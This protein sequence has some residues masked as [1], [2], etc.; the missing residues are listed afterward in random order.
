MTSRPRPP[1]SAQGERDAAAADGSGRVAHSIAQRTNAGPAVPNLAATSGFGDVSCAN[2]APRGRDERLG[3][4]THLITA[5]R[6]EHGQHPLSVLR[7]DDLHGS[8]VGRVG[9]ALHAAVA[10]RAVDELD[11]AGVTELELI[12]E[13]ADR[14]LPP[15]N[16]LTTSRSW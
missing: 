8:T 15:R 5:Q 16:A 10:L 4:A 9:S 13:L 12:G 2:R 1:H 7:E 14:P 3:H 6:A 11:R